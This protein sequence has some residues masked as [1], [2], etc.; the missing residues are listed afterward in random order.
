MFGKRDTSNK[1]EEIHIQMLRKATIAK[2]F[3]STSSLSKTVVQLS[4]RAIRRNRP[5]ITEQE[6]NDEFVSLHYGKELA[7]KVKRFIKEK[8][9]M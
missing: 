9:M 3:A 1:I 4:K 6:V 8:N 5:Y 7:E 2:R